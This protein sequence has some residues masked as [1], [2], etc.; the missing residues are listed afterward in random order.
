MT[1]D[2]VFAAALEKTN[3]TERATFLDLACAGDAA[4]RVRVEARLRTHQPAKDVPTRIL[5]EHVPIGTPTPRPGEDPTW[6]FPEPPADPA[7]T[8]IG[9]YRLVQKLGEGGM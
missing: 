4:L 7:A 9:P 8:R 2:T 6:T 3:P 5:D 1:E